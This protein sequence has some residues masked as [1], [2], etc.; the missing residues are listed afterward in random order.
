MRVVNPV[1]GPHRS[2]LLPAPNGL[3]AL[4]EHLVEMSIERIDRFD[5]AIFAIRMPDDDYVA[6]AAVHIVGKNNYALADARH[7][8]AKIAI[9]AADAIP[10]FAEMV[11]RSVAPR[12]V[13]TLGIRLTDRKI[14]AVR[15]P[16]VGDI[17]S[18]ADLDRLC[19][20]RRDQ[21]YAK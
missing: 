8:V 6:P 16:R 15:Q 7:R 4:H 10:I 12:F 18:P 20:C 21:R 3:A 11:I 9:A 14:E 5:L 19:C 13:I 2:D 17:V 1:R